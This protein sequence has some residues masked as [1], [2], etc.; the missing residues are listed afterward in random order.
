M[1]K[2][3]VMKSYEKA[4]KRYERLRNGYEFMKLRN[5]SGMKLQS[6]EIVAPPSGIQYNAMV[7]QRQSYSQFY[8]KQI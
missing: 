2:L 6:Y 8:F 1:E 5:H 3:K 7:H 4:T